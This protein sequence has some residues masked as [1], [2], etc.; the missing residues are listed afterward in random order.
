MSSRHRHLAMA[1]VDV[2]FGHEVPAADAQR[3][4]HAIM[5]VR[6]SWPEPEDALAHGLPPPGF[7]RCVNAEYSVD[8]RRIS[9]AS[10]EPVAY[11][12]LLMEPIAPV[13][14]GG[15]RATDDRVP[16]QESYPQGFFP[17]TPRTPRDPMAS[18]QKCFNCGS[19][20]HRLADC[21][22]VRRTRPPR[23]P[24]TRPHAVPARS[25]GTRRRS[26]MRG[27]NSSPRRPRIRR[28]TR[29]AC[30]RGGLGPS[31][32]GLP[33][34]ARLTRPC[35]ALRS[36]HISVSRDP[37]MPVGMAHLGAGRLSAAARAALGTLGAALRGCHPGE[38]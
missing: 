24:P 33:R 29:G 13:A 7:E 32:A 20:R 1:W 30:C 5:S 21:P 22:H 34:F 19:N 31:A 28:R 11:S 38:R 26:R 23:C 4:L 25:Q 17:Q 9:A 37:P 18:D 27:E 15:A 3:I 12:A 2:R 14:R 36:Y 10:R 16:E 8:R 6:S 35:L